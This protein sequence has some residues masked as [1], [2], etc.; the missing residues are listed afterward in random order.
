MYLGSVSIV[1]FV[2]MTKVLPTI[3]ENMSKIQFHFYFLCNE[4]EYR[5]DSANRRL[6]EQR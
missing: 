1:K 5:F 2:Q 6:L 4:F 3:S